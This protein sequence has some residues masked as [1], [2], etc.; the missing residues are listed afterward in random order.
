MSEETS[1]TPTVQTSSDAAYDVVDTVLSSQRAAAAEAARLRDEL[2]AQRWQSARERNETWQRDVEMRMHSPAVGQ[3]LLS[4]KLNGGD[5][6]ILA[7]RAMCSA[8]DQG[9]AIGTLARYEHGAEISRIA[10]QSRVWEERLRTAGGS[11]VLRE[12]QGAAARL[13][14]IRDDVHKKLVTAEGQVARK[15]VVQS[16]TGLGYTVEQRG[17]G[18]RATSGRTCVWAMVNKGTGDLHLDMSG[19]SGLECQT[20]L[21]RIEREIAQRGLSL[22]RSGGTT[23][24]RPDG[25]VLARALGATGGSMQAGKAATVSPIGPSSGRKKS[26]PLSRCTGQKVLN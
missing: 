6:D 25:G 14:A 18:L 26:T 17:E 23:H 4:Q 9:N 8:L 5:R 22:R 16:L 12:V 21:K 2:R 11:H 24:G 20:A 7:V 19:F 13:Q 1:Y 10:E 3:S 15:L